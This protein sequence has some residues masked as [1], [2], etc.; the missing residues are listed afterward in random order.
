M[1]LENLKLKLEVYQ[2]LIDALNC[3]NAVS[4]AANDEISSFL[5]CVVL[6]WTHFAKLCYLNKS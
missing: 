1:E 4:V 3:A 5:I 2:A 6:H